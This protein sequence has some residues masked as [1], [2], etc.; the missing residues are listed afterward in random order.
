MPFIRAIILNFLI[1]FLFMTL[2][3]AKL[4]EIKTKQAINNI[5]FISKNGK[6][7]YF[8]N[9]SGSL[10]VSFNYQISEIF[11]SEKYTDFLVTASHSQKKI[12]ISVQKNP[13]RN[14]WYFNDSEL[15]ISDAGSTK[16]I[17]IGMGVNPRFHQNAQFISYYQ[18]LKSLIVIVNLKNLTKSY[19]IKLLNSSNPYFIPDVYMITPNDVVYTDNNSKGHSA[20]LMYSLFDKSFET[21]YKSQEKSKK[22]EICIYNDAAIIGEFPYNL[23]GK[24]S[25]LT[26]IDLFNNLKFQNSEII[27]STPFADIGNMICKGDEIY[28]IK[29]SEYQRKI[30]FKK[31][32]IAV[33]NL[34]NNIAKKITDLGDVTQITRMGELILTP[35]KGQ[36][37]VVSGKNK[38]RDDA[39]K[40]EKP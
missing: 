11:K 28:F 6:M 9:Q 30:H 18:P 22:L 34:K 38:V 35:Y 16:V 21:I 39:I 37:L 13:H 40:R 15:Y 17:K 29:T 2:A 32:D 36:I 1:S 25:S 19:K 31:T 14:N 27:Y 3:H 8:K 33:F 26:K 24:N 10:K 7:T 20:V 4:E 23:L 12:A 5:R